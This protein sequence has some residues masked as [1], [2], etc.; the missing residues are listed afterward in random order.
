MQDSFIKLQTI[1]KHIITITIECG[2][3][4]NDNNS[5]TIDSEEYINSFNPEM[6]DVTYAWAA[7]AKFS[8]ICKMTDIFEGIY[9]TY[10]L[11]TYVH[12]LYTI[13]ECILYEYSLCIYHV[14]YITAYI[15]RRVS[16]YTQS[17]TFT[18]YLY[19]LY[20]ICTI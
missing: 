12:T 1:A 6:I 16:S 8:D 15:I 9:K 5:D 11:Y 19:T 2:G 4:T 3:N 18:L 14:L 17:H 7:G 10:I 13:H 20:T